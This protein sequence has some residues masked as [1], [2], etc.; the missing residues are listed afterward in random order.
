MRTDGVFNIAAIKVP[1]KANDYITLIPFGDI[2]WDSPAH[3]RDEWETFIRTVKTYHNP[4]FLGMGDYMDGYSTSERR[5]VYSHDLHESTLK[6]QERDTYKRLDE[7][8]SEIAWMKGRIIGI[9]GGNH[10]PVFSD[11]TTGDQYIARKL[12]AQYLGACAAIRLTLEQGKSRSC[13]L[14]IFA[15]HGKGGGI[16][17]GGR[18]NAVEKLQNVCEADIYLMGDN[19]ARGCL[20][21]GDKLR[22]VHTSAGLALSCRKQWIG[23][24]GSFLKSYSPG[25]PSY[26]VDSALPPASLGW[27]SFRLTFARL[28][29]GG[30][31]NLTVDIRADQ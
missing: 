8:V 19:H 30:K 27:I 14:D 7:F 11:G 28:R 4:Y 29:D 24:T 9:L 2:H 26:V 16:T 3:A 13:A 15:H 17:A 1:C 6:R 18:L 25:S 20:P 12:G 23:R 31:D 5:I 22:L 10:Y 21:L